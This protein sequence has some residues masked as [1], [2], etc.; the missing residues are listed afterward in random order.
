M[1]PGPL[2]ILDE[3]WTLSYVANVS[4]LIGLTIT[5]IGFWVTIRAVRKSRSAAE[6]AEKAAK[7]ARSNLLKVDSIV[8]ISGV[9][10]GLEDVKRLHRSG[11]WN[12]MPERY[13]I[14]RRMLIEVRT[15]NLNLTDSQKTTLQSAIQQLSV[16]E[17][18]IEE[19]LASPESTPDI[20]KL[21]G[22]ISK[23]ADNLTQ[24]LTELKI[25]GER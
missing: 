21:N 5:F 15:G 7:D 4:E 8:G 22:I 6:A 1:Q 17:K 2:P 20:A 3:G 11:S 13:G 23:H 10:S 25:N 9:I 24:L 16:M 19:H 12:G 14:Q 18:Q